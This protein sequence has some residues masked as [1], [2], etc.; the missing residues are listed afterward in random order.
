MSSIEF[1][2]ISDNLVFRVWLI[3]IVIG[4]LDNRGVIFK[5]AYTFRA[6]QGSGS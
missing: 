1:R 6:F 4:I 5:N 3:F 2:I